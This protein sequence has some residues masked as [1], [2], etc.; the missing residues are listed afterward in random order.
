MQLEC[1]LYVTKLLLKFFKITEKLTGTIPLH[2]P[3]MCSCCRMVAK[4]DTIRVLVPPLQNMT[5]ELVLL[6]DFKAF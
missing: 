4:T 1:E 3:K 6:L 2:N 5:S